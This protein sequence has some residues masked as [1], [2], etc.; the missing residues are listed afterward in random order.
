MPWS[1]VEVPT[2]EIFPALAFEYQRPHEKLG[3]NGLRGYFRDIDWLRLFSEC[4][5]LDA[6]QSPSPSPGEPNWEFYPT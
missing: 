6:D 3:E 2:G 4:P 5:I 1:A